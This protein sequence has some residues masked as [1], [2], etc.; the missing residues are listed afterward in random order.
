[1]T[2]SQLHNE[3]KVIIAQE[4]GCNVT[5]EQHVHLLTE[6]ELDAILGKVINLMIRIAVENIGQKKAGSCAGNA[7]SREA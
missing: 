2:P 6:Q 1:M 5:W 7:G 4:T 3:I